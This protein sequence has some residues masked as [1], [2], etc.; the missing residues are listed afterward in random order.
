MLGTAKVM[1]YEGLKKARAER[2]VKDE[3]KPKGKGRRGRKT[4]KEEQGSWISGRD[5]RTS[6][7]Q[8]VTAKRRAALTKSSSGGDD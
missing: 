8:N 6:D 7:D 3:A 5:A 4:R 2:I 1:S